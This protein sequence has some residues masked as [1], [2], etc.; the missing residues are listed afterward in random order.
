MFTIQKFCYALLIF[1]FLSSCSRSNKELPLS[2]GKLGTLTVVADADVHKAISATLDQVFLAEDASFTGGSPFSELLK[3]APDEFFQFFN[4]QKSILVLVTEDSKGKL[5]DVLEDFTDEEINKYIQNSGIDIKESIDKFAKCQHIVF[6]FGKDDASIQSKLKSAEKKLRVL[7]VDNEIKDQYGLLYGQNAAAMDDGTAMRKEL[8][9][10]FKVPSDFKLIEHRNGFWW[11]ESNIEN[12]NASRKIGLIAHAY[13]YQDS[14]LD[15]T[16]SKI[17]ANRDSVIKY[18]IKGEIKGTYMGTSESEAYP[19]RHSDV[20]QINGHPF[21]KIRAWW[22][23]DGI[24]MSGPFIRYV[25]RVPGTS[26]IFAFEGFIY[27]PELNIKEK[28]LRIIESIA[29]SIK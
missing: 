20:V 24:M 14:A 22:N 9:M 18:H 28:D 2:V 6:L 23:I 5:D 27:K 29:L 11:F 8:G 17:C 19:A 13:P 12:G 25:T 15:F 7:L 16:Y 4:N 10:G 26:T 3:P 21:T 1:L